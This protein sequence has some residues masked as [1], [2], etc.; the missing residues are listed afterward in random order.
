MSDEHAQGD[1]RHRGRPD[2]RPRPGAAPPAPDRRRP[3]R[4]APGRAPGRAAV[5]PLGRLHGA[6]LRVVLRF[7]IGDDPDVIGGLGASNV[8]IGGFLG[9]ALLCI[10]VGAIQW[11]RKL[12]GDHEIIE[13]RHPATSSD[14][15]REEALEAFNAGVTESG[16]GRRP[17]IRN[18]LL[19]AMGALGPAGRDLPARPRSAARATSWRT[20]SGRRTCASCRTSPAPRSSR[21][22]SRSASWSTPSR[23]SSTR[24]DP[25]ASRCTRAPRCCRPRPRPPRSWSG[26]TPT[27][28]RPARAARTG[29]S[30]GILCFSKIC[31]HVGCP[32]SLWEQQTHHLLCP[33]HQSTFD[34]ADNGRVIFGPAARSLPQ[35]PITVDKARDTWWRAATSPSQS[36]RATG[37]EGDSEMKT[38]SRATAPRPRRPAKPNRVGAVA[39]WADERL[40]LADAGQEADPQG[41]PGP[42]VL[43]ARRD[44]AVELRRPAPDRHVPHAVVPAEHGRDRLQR[45]LRPAARSGDVRGLRLDAEHL[46]RR[47]RRPAD[48][49]DAPL[50]RDAVHRRDAGA[51]DARLLHRRVPQAAR[52]QLGDRLACCCSSA[53]SRA[54]PATRCPTTCSPAPASAPPT[55]S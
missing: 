35:L 15:D 5:R 4:R 52:A 32:I 46:L 26:C 25:T 9:L 47:P 8:A 33:C 40:G 21:P 45:L 55:A 37:N 19:G 7:Q 36:A 41:L 18:S 53:R 24:T 13:M 27:T 31:T 42:L 28:S 29:A 17:L 10:G 50:G 6:V 54:S 3:R 20:R 14:E 38:H 30:T 48:A 16:I 11:A 23:A 49:P 22:T 1:R 12:M 39:E 2:R 51:P 43:H 34:L 44:R